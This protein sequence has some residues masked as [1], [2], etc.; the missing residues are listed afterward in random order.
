MLRL[1]DA[2][3]FDYDG[4]DLVYGRGSVG[5][6][7][8]LLDGYGYER[9]VVVTGSNVGSNPG[10]IDPVRAGLGDHL[11]EVFDQTTPAKT[12]ATA[13]DGIDVM[14]AVEPDVLVSVGGGSSLDIARQMSVFA[15][16]GRSLEWFEEAAREGRSL[17]PS[18]T[19]PVTPVVVVPTTFAG[20]DVSGGGSIEVLGPEASPSGQPVRMSGW[21]QPDAMVYDPALFE[22]TPMGALAGSAMNGF[23]K[24]I[25]T[26]YSRAASPL[27]D[28]TAVRGLRYLRAGFP[29]L[30]GDPEAV[31]RSILGIILVQFRRETS[32]VH[33][34]G[35]GFS[36]RYDLQQG[37]AHA[38]LVP[39]IL[40]FVFSRV[41]GSRG[42][43]AEGLGVDPAG[44]SADAVA[45]GVVE[46]VAAVRDS[47]GL[48]TQLRELDV[49][50]Q[51]D[52]RAIAEFILEDPA[53][54]RGPVG[55]DPSVEELEDVLAAAW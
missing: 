54:E 34:F 12:A 16:D 14:E 13:F 8:E 18:P 51:G 38:V 46:E 42:V 41:D 50:D 29:G 44:K 32:I 33:A 30:P 55:L 11:V 22:T 37:V 24:G 48:P 17:S 2:F 45:E 1:V 40:R 31:E 43:L 39:H 10:V 47:L 49:V 53:M 7:G 25:E 23:N 5:R 15:A 52:F 26:P 9:A 36:R 35:H 28:A 4:S 20:A 6:L 3:E 27:T 21:V 19:G